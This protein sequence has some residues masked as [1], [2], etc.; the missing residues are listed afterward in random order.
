M[1]VADQDRRS[2][3]HRS[4][5]G[6]QSATKFLS[7]EDVETKVASDG[8]SADF[9]TEFSTPTHPKDKKPR[10]RGFLWLQRGDRTLGSGFNCSLPNYPKY[11]PHVLHQDSRDR[12]D[13]ADVVFGMVGEAGARHEI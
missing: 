9:A 7:V 6:C 3:V 13:G 5:A 12:G 10:Y 8:A 4:I 11:I 1:I 2:S